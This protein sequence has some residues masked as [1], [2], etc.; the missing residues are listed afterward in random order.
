MKFEYWIIIG[1]VWFIYKAVTNAAKKNKA[2][3]QRGGQNSNN[4]A[5]TSQ[6]FQE[7]AT[8]T[9]SS[10]GEGRS[11]ETHSAE[12]NSLERIVAEQT[13]NMFDPFL[14]EPKS[15]ENNASAHYSESALVAEYKRTHE[16][17]KTVAH[18]RH[19]LFNEN[20][21]RRKAES[22]AK[23]LAHRASSA[24]AH[25]SGHSPAPVPAK[26]AERTKPESS[27]IGEELKRP[28]NLKQAFILSEVL[29]RLED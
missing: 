15:L 1:V 2:N 13:R 9:A 5:N 6:V 16:A 19:Q 21:D 4:S 22:H 14:E 7:R 25:L 20:K 18:H 27:P 8:E 3:L 17:G 28:G 29:R 23:S 24:R 11:L 26:R 12:G 10:R